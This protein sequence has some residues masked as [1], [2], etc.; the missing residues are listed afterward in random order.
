MN[1]HEI[2]VLNEKAQQFRI[3][4]PDVFGYDYLWKVFHLAGNDIPLFFEWIVQCY[5]QKEH[6][7][8]ST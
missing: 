2:F 4:H 5:V 3:D 8:D 1:T 6:T 7:H